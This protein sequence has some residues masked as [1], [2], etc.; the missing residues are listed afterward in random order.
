MRTNLPRAIRALRS[1]RGWRQ[2]DLAARAGA[3]RHTVS[4]IERGR[5][6]NVPLG[7]ITTIVAALDATLDLSLRWQ[8]ERLDRL[9]DAAH[10]TV[11]NHMTA[12]LRSSGWTV[13]VEVSFNHYGD[14]GRV[15]VLAFHPGSGCLLVGEVK[16]AIGDVQDMLGRLDVKM[17]IG[18][19]LAR[20]AGWMPIRHVVPA[21]MCLDGRTARRVV[22]DHPFLFAK[23]GCRGRSAHRWLWKPTVPAPSGL[24]LFVSLPNAHGVRGK[25]GSRVRR[26]QMPA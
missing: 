4:R 11:Q 20:Q 22:A 15:D 9:I 23:L 18:P 10:A 16:S 2:S 25:R 14:R 17:R 21:V 24:L 19:I 3:S 7:K 1:E 26:R 12:E 5:L 6:D 13:D 8:G